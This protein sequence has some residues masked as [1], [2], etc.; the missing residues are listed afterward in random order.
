[1]SVFWLVLAILAWGVVHSLL[2]SLA[3]KSALQARLGAGLM[4][5]YRLAYNIFALLS[6][7]PIL[8]LVAFLPDRS[9]YQ[10]PAPW[11]Y[12]MLGVQ[13]LAAFLLIAGVLQTDTFSFI[14][15]RQLIQE[16][17][18]VSL[19]T[20]GL[21]RYVRHPLYSAGLLFLWVSPVMTVNSLTMTLG[22]TVYIVIGAMFEERKLLREFG[23]AYAEYGRV[24]PMLVPGFRFDR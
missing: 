7:L 12:L 15:I 5:L 3:V 16:E 2:A 10:V 4:R 21:Y 18:P 8:W 6:F 14:G 13:A 11:S 17:K 20:G 24:T 23:N 9:L 22:L 1:M 19:M